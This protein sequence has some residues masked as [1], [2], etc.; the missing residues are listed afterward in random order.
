M[1]NGHEQDP[2]VEAD[3]PAFDV[4]EVVLDPLAQRRSAAPAVDLGPAGH[5][6]GTACRRS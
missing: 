5:A 4:V 2:Q 3:R 6:A 1:L